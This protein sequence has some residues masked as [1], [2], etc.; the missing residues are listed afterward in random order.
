MSLQLAVR[1]VLLLLL[2]LLVVLSNWGPTR[3]RENK[4]TQKISWAFILAVGVGLA[5]IGVLYFTDSSEYGTAW[6]MVGLAVIPACVVFASVFAVSFWEPIIIPWVLYFV[7][8]IFHFMPVSREFQPLE[9]LAVAAVLSLLTSLPG[10]LALNLSRRFRRGHWSWSLVRGLGWGMPCAVG[11]MFAFRSKVSTDIAF[12]DDYTLVW[13]M[14]AEVVLV[15]A[16]AGIKRKRPE[17]KPEMQHGDPMVAMPPTQ[18]VTQ[19]TSS[20]NAQETTPVGWRAI[21]NWGRWKG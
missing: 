11:T 1:G 9:Y 12:R 21:R 20:Q 5:C 17:V 4:P 18:V 10:C 3:R 19:G 15:T 2:G 16:V 6:A 7:P 14:L 8:A 13:V